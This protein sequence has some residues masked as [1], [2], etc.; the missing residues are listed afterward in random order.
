MIS[1]NHGFLSLG[2]EQWPLCVCGTWEQESCSSLN[3]KQFHIPNPGESSLFLVSGWRSCRKNCTDHLKLKIVMKNRNCCSIHAVCPN[4]C[5]VQF[6]E[7]LSLLSQGPRSEQRRR[8]R[9]R[10]AEAEAAGQEELQLPPPQGPLEIVKEVV[11]EDGTV[12]TIKQ[13]IPGA[14][15]DKDSSGS[16]EEEEEEGEALGQPVE[17][18]PRCSAMVAVK[19]GVLYVYGGMFEVGDRQVT[20]SDLHCIDLHRMEQW[21][22]LLDM[23]PSEFCS[24][25]LQGSNTGGENQLGVFE[26]R[27]SVHRECVVMQGI[28]CE[29]GVTES[30][31]ICDLETQEL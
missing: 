5:W 19:H 6:P 23:D 13:V 27:F 7:K 26:C 17:P 15:G 14:A 31:L 4:C 2:T 18:C 30:A 1:G 24:L 16:E 28:G 29:P 22:V 11:A 10:Q 9:G 20:L 8:R 21:K 12:M 25:C 3:R